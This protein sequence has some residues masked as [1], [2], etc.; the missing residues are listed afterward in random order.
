MIAEDTFVSAGG[1]EQGFIQE[2]VKEGYVTVD[3]WPSWF[4]DTERF[5]FSQH[6]AYNDCTV[7]M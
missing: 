5:Y 4:N 2:A 7:K 3:F 1:F 6:L